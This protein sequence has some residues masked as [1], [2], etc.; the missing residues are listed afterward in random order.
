MSKVLVT[1]GCGA[2]GSRLIE[3]LAA[4]GHRVLDCAATTAPLRD[5]EVVIADLSDRGALARATRDVEI[6]FHLAA[7]VHVTDPTPQLLERYESVKV[8]GTRNVVEAAR[9]A[10]VGRVVFFS[11]IRSTGRRGR[12]RRTT[13]ARRS[14]PI[15]G[16]RRARRS[17]NEWLSRR[18]RL[19]SF[20]SRRSTVR[21]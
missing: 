8:D 2:I 9:S 4:A 12:A 1:G 6:V 19:S 17:R 14:D 20:A 13:K 16:M 7:V 21:G 15:R 10:G 11:T 18:C 5:V 3:R